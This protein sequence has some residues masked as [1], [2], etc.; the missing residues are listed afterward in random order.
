MANFSTIDGGLDWQHVD[1]INELLTSMRERQELI[2]QSQA[3]LASVGTDISSAAFWAILQ[4]WVLS[5]YDEFIDEGV[6]IDENTTASFASFNYQSLADF[7]SEAGINANGFRK[8]TVWVPGTVDGTWENDVTF[9]YGVIEVGDIIG[10][11]LFDDL[12][13][14]FR[15]LL[16][17]GRACTWEWQL[18]GTDNNIF[19]EYLYSGGTYAQAYGNRWFGGNSEISAYAPRFYTGGFESYDEFEV[20]SGGYAATNSVENNAKVA[21]PTSLTG[22]CYYYPFTAEATPGTFPY[23]YWDDHDF[24]FVEDAWNLASTDAFSTGGTAYSSGIGDRTEDPPA[25]VNTNRVD[26]PDTDA[27]TIHYG[28]EGWE[29]TNIYAVVAPTYSYV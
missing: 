29:A 15:A 8:A 26:D 28:T 14:A 2:S 21:T 4:N 1:F 24:G 18:S 13:K 6:T 3:A 17:R 20:L 10:P 16:K 22:T 27:Y 23:N 25:A 5:N 19:G 11:W 7:Y 12:I 9:T